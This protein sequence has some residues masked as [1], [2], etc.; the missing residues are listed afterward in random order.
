MQINTNISTGTDYKVTNKNSKEVDKEVY[1]SFDQF[2]PGSKEK[3][4][5]LQ[6]SAQLKKMSEHEKSKDKSHIKIGERLKGM[7]EMIDEAEEW[8]I[9]GTPYHYFSKL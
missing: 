3:D 1:E 8:A 4:E 2:S 9:L 6:M 5:T 7:K